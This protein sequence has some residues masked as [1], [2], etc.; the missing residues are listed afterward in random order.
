MKVHIL[1]SHRFKKPWYMVSWP[2]T[3]LSTW[4]PRKWWHGQLCKNATAILD[5]LAIPP[6]WQSRQK[7]SS[8]DWSLHF[9]KVYQW[10]GWNITQFNHI[11]VPRLVSLNHNF[12]KPLYLPLGFAIP[13]ATAS[14][15]GND[16]IMG[17]FLGDCNC[18]RPKPFSLDPVR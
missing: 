9:Q 6:F 3:P 5:S 15:E 18:D 1:D 7:L 11:H 13:T 12:L 17:M 16:L 4:T 14:K 8:K 10:L 2:H